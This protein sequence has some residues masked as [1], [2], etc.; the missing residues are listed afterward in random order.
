MEQIRGHLM[1]GARTIQTMAKTSPDLC[2]V[3]LTEGGIMEQYQTGSGPALTDTI[4]CQN[5]AAGQI[6]QVDPQYL[7]LLSQAFGPE[8]D[9]P[10]YL[11]LVE[12]GD[13]G[14]QLIVA[15]DEGRT[16]DIQGIYN[17]HSHKLILG[18]MHPNDGYRV[19]FCN[20]QSVVF[21]DGREPL[22]AQEGTTF[23]LWGRP[24][25]PDVWQGDAVNTF[26]LTKPL[27]ETLVPAPSSRAEIQRG[28]A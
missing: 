27:Q 23:N 5:G 20:V 8:N 25:S 18:D 22:Q 1:D 13:V 19:A 26:H 7:P 17:D 21:D 2:L 3:V 11:H 4:D 14:V 16:K 24:P 12:E 6:I 9:W 28:G 10:P 15:N